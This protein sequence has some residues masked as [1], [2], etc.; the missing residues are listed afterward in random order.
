MN[1]FELY[2]PPPWNMH[3]NPEKTEGWIEF[4]RCMRKD[5]KHYLEDFPKIDWKYIIKEQP[6]H[7]RKI[8]EIHE[9]YEGHY[10]IGMRD[11]YQQCPFKDVLDYYELNELPYPNF[12]WI[13]AEDFPFPE[14]PSTNFLPKSTKLVE[15][16]SVQDS[17]L[18]G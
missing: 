4:Q 3:E 5:P 2:F 7:N 9:S 16:E 8:V 6:E 17:N 14:F 18:Q 12:F 13:Y 10:C 15:C 11:Y 1:E